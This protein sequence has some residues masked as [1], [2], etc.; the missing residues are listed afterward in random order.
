[1]KVRLVG[2]VPNE[3]YTIVSNSILDRVDL[4]AVEKMILICLMRNREGFTQHRNALSDKVGVSR[5]TLTTKIKNLVKLG[6]M[7]VVGQERTGGKFADDVFEASIEPIF[8]EQNN[9]AQNLC[10]VEND[11]TVPNLTT[12]KNTVPKNWALNKTNSNKTT[13]NKINKNTHTPEKSIDDLERDLSEKEKD[14]CQ[15]LP[16][17][18]QIL[19]FDWLV[20]LPGGPS[21]GL[22]LRSLFKHFE[23][24]S[25][26]DLTEQIE[27]A[28][29]GKWYGLTE[30][31]NTKSTPRNKSVQHT[32][33]E[34]PS[35]ERDKA[36]KEMA[37]KNEEYG[38]RL[39][40]NPQGNF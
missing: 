20:Y 3:E 35:T 17:T 11:P 1:M 37:A 22:T 15:R 19:F 25:A 40:Q 16:D 12:P 8:L 18:K 38:R 7:R 36:F 39:A 6:F 21:K 10:M 31:P 9:H 34:T 14:Y 2:S 27:K 23:K 13:S 33:N 29:A 5:N 4:G 30:K 32:T 28:T 26:Q 24:Y